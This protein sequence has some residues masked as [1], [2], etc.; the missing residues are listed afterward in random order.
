MFIKFILV[1]LLFSFLGEFVLKILWN[2]D[3][4]AFLRTI[5]IYTLLL[6]A[7]Y[8]INK[9]LDYNI[10]NKFRLNLIYYLISGLLG[11]VVIE[12][13]ILGTISNPIPIQVGMFAFWTVTFMMPRLFTSDSPNL[14]KIK[15]SALKFYL[16]Y[17]TGTILVGLL[18]PS[19][20]KVFFLAWFMTI[21][22]IF[23]NSYL[24]KFIV[25][26]PLKNGPI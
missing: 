13:I 8:F 22:Y 2:N 24:G 12:W 18:L 14:D 5:L 10:S 6:A 9:I 19:E 1:G 11:L 21:G 15:K 4:G 17:T 16:W 7:L 3:P 20:S 23:L 26:K 25:V